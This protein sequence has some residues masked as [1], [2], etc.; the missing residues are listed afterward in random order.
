MVVST[1][2]GVRAFVG[3]GW[4]P[5]VGKGLSSNRQIFDQDGDVV[6][7]S[8]SPEK[9][10]LPLGGNGGENTIAKAITRSLHIELCS[11]R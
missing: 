5:I 11:W 8:G 6:S 9:P 2:V 7:P 4:S 3:I 1:S 10:K